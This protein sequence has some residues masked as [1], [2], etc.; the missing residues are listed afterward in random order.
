[1]IQHKIIL[2]IHL[3][4]CLWVDSIT[5]VLCSRFSTKHCTN[6]KVSLRTRVLKSGNIKHYSERRNKEWKTFYPH[7]WSIYITAL[8]NNFIIRHLG[9]VFLTFF[10]LVSISHC[11]SHYH[12]LFITGASS[13]CDSTVSH[14]GEPWK[15]TPAELMPN[16]SHIGGSILAKNKQTTISVCDTGRITNWWRE[17][18]ETSQAFNFS[19]SNKYPHIRGLSEGTD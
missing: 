13:W 11:I 19:I 18:N 7:V 2:L 8:Q 10:F 16:K 4:D 12:I 17:G 9:G 5:F 15:Q 14:S 6:H 3:H 1:M